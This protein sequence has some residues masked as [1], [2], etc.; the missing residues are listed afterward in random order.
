MT[1]CKYTRAHAR[2]LTTNTRT[3]HK[4]AHTT[5]TLSQSEQFIITTVKVILAE[6]VHVFLC[7]NDITEYGINNSNSLKTKDL[8]IE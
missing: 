1:G 4:H 7:L 8:A 6:V 2:A 5:N 3:H